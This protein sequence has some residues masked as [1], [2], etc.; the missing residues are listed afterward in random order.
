MRIY[1]TEMDT[2][3]KPE[4]IES[5]IRCREMCEACDEAFCAYN[6]LNECRLPLVNGKKPRLHDNG[7]HDYVYRETDWDPE[8]EWDMDPS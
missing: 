4:E 8:D 5:V 1:I 2:E 6:F 7:C 3:L